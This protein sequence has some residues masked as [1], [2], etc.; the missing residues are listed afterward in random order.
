MP[1][2]C[3]AFSGDVTGEAEA[4]PA[5]P[6]ASIEREWEQTPATVSRVATAGQSGRYAQMSAYIQP[7]SLTIH[8]LTAQATSH[9]NGA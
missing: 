5:A 8:D 1:S 3:H 4:A 2:W 6:T 7:A 9:L